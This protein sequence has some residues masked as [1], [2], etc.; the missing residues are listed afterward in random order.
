MKLTDNDFKQI[1]DSI[2]KNS[3]SLPQLQAILKIPEDTL[4][5]LDIIIKEA[6]NPDELFKTAMNNVLKISE[7]E[8]EKYFMSLLCGKKCKNSFLLKAYLIIKYPT[9]FSHTLVDLTNVNGKE[10]LFLNILYLIRYKKTQ[11]VYDDQEEDECFDSCIEENTIIELLGGMKPNTVKICLPYLAGILSF[12]NFQKAITEFDMQSFICIMNLVPKYIFY[13]LLA[14]KLVDNDIKE[15]ILLINSFEFINNAILMQHVSQRLQSL[16]KQTSD[17]VLFTRSFEYFKICWVDEA[18]K[19]KILFSWLTVFIYLKKIDDFLVL[20]S[21]I[22]NS[23]K[24]FTRHNDFKV[25]EKFF[26]GV[27]NY[28]LHKLMD[29]GPFYKSCLEYRPINDYGILQI[30]DTAEKYNF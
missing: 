27:M 13:R 7:N 2:D 21:L 3:L 6:D 4:Q 25:Y 15:G 16:Y 29:F 8:I 1:C 19:C 10:H 20:F 9:Q 5:F 17:F 11:V 24:E 12:D 26:D 18:I 23:Y 30:R 14:S 22:S 28:K